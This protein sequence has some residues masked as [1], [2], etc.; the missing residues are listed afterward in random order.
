MIDLITLLIH[1]L[2]HV[3]ITENILINYLTVIAGKLEALEQDNTGTECLEGGLVLEAFKAEGAL[4]LC[5][6]KAC[7]SEV[8]IDTVDFFVNFPSGMFTR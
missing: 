1:L 3:L 4:C 8:N 2:I 6:I 7:L 5:V